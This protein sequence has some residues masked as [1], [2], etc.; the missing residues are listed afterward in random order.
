MFSKKLTVIGRDILFCKD[1][2][3]LLV[4]TYHL[5]RF[6]KGYLKQVSDRGGIY[7]LMAVSQ[8]SNENFTKLTYNLLDYIQKVK[9]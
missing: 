3:C 1:P 5:D 4:D 9:R 2:A 6:S 7:V 8:I